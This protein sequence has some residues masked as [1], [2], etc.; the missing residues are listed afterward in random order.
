MTC[1]VV[2]GTVKFYKCAWKAQ[3]RVLLVEVLGHVSFRS[4]FIHASSQ[5]DVLVPIIIVWVLVVIG[6][7]PVLGYCGRCCSYRV[8]M[9]K[10]L[11]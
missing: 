5:Q 6:M 11:A 7:T 9:A 10:R 4:T 1:F 2:L 8:A 3:C